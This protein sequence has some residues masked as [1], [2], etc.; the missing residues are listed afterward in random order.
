M[1]HSRPPD[2]E[3]RRSL[4]QVPG[5]L[6]FDATYG[7]GKWLSPARALQVLSSGQSYSSSQLSAEE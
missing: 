5:A 3:L 7:A 2:K 4:G 6:V 1:R